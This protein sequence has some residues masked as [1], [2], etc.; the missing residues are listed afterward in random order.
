MR[1]SL[2]RVATTVV[3]GLLVVACAS[4]ASPP[5]ATI[6]PPTSSRP[7][8]IPPPTSSPPAVSPAITAI[9]AGGDHTCALTSGGGVKCWG[10]NQYG[11]LG[12]GTTTQTA[13]P[14]AVDVSGLASGVTA[15]SAGGVHTC[16]LTSGG[17]VKCWGANYGSV[18]VDVAGLA[19]G[20][21]AIAAGYEHTCAVTSGGGVRC[22][23]A[24]YSG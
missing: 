9:A 15:I 3:V 24:N 7:A 12:N 2:S 4:P 8:T 10:A 23:G 5:P 16:A 1:F 19:S 22:W 6:P 11:Q 21:A 14:V 17:G 13:V 18:P 20:V